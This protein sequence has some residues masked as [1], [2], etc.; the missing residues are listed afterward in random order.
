MMKK[1]IINSIT[2]DKGSEFNNKDFL[3]YC[4]DNDI[5]VYLI[6]DDSHKLGIINRFHRSLKELLTLFFTKYDTLK[7]IDVIDDIIKIYNRRFNRGIGCAPIEVNSFI[8]NEIIQSNKK[9]TA[10]IQNNE[11][12]YK[13]GDKVLIKN[14]RGLFDDKMNLKYSSTVYKVISVTSNS[15]IV[16]DDKSKKFIV[17]KSD[18]IM[19]VG[20]DKIS[21]KIDDNK[22]IS[23]FDNRMKKTGLDS[24]DI[25]EGKR[26]IK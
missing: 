5:Y 6:K 18:M 13:E 25:L 14:K 20:N 9:K 1:T 12:D 24:K 21:N 22:N 23:R 16:I 4:E 3:E 26:R 17:K 10:I 2:C 8:E 15:C 19:Y 11:V 7:W